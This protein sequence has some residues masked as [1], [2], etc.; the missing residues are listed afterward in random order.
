ML[1]TPSVTRPE[2]GLGLPVA[3]FLLGAVALDLQFPVEAVNV[4][5]LV[6]MVGALTASALAVTARMRAGILGT[7]LLAQDWIYGA[8]VLLVFA[9]VLWSPAP[10]N[11]A[12]Q[13]IYL[14]TVFIASVQLGDASITVFNRVLL[15]LAFGVAILSLLAAPVSAEVAF[16]P[17][18]S[19][20]I[21]EL[22]GVF[23]HQLRLGLFMA[24]ALGVC[25]IAVLN[26]EFRS[27]LGNSRLL[28]SIVVVVLVVTLVAAFA[29]LYTA[30]MLL[31]LAIVVGL[32]HRGPR[33]WLMGG[34][35]TCAIGLSVWLG[36][37]LVLWLEGVGVDTTLTN[38]VALW[39]RT[40][41]LAGSKPWLGFGY[42]SF[43][44]GSF[45]RLFGYYRPAHPHN[46]YLQAYFE[47]GLIGLGLTL[48]LIVAQLR[49]G[50][51]YARITGRYSY[52]IFIVS[53]TAIGSLTGSNYAGKPTLLFSVLLVIVAIEARAGRRAERL[54]RPNRLRSPVSEAAV[55]VSSP[56]SLQEGGS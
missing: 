51:R 47:T 11:T 43:D 22:R 31:S 13:S 37:D 35:L 10:L 14:A 29:R 40:G 49:S 7:S 41:V 18:A 44:H 42:A 9:S 3:I 16:Q 28:R 17:H 1:P 55:P 48:M 20:D 21:P 4:G 39:E 24:L 34:F 8:Y 25:T 15:V 6:L 54:E 52:S 33:R 23:S 36:S 12:V 46:S 5:N 26:G 53:F 38:R 45:D 56:G 50:F 32:S 19:T 2:L 30:A 27:V